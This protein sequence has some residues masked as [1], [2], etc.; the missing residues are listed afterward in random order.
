VE[1]SVEANVIEFEIWQ[2]Y[3]PV[4][5]KD[6][7]PLYGVMTVEITHT[8]KLTPQIVQ[9]TVSLTRAGGVA[10]AEDVPLSIRQQADDLGMLTPGPQSVVFTFGPAT[11][12]LTLTEREMIGGAVALT[13]AGENVQLTLPEVALYFTH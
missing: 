9:G 2:D 7:A 5:P 4:V 12:Q 3:M 8:E 13:V 1:G 10:V 11:M 6:G